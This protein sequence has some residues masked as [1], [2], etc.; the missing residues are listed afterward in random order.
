MDITYAST[1][2]GQTLAGTVAGVWPVVTGIVVVGVLIGAV[3]YGIQRR[4]RE[5][6]PPAG[7]Q[8][9]AG[10]WHTREELDSGSP[11]GHGPGH[12]DEGPHVRRESGRREPE[13]VPRDG[14]RRKPQEIRDYGS[15]PAGP[16][17]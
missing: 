16:A 1:N 13:E 14:R 17:E 6:A 10:A 15:R 5:H 11:A 9:R 8:P 7:P 12:Q 2:D 3:Y 4:A